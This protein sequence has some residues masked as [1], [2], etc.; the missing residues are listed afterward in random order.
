[1]TD[2][3]YCDFDRSWPYEQIDRIARREHKCDECFHVIHQHEPYERA[4]GLCEGKWFASKTCIR[5]LALREY[6]VAHVPCCCWTHGNM[7]EDVMGSVEEYAYATV[8]LA[9]GALRR[10]VL[11][12]R[13]SG[14][15]YECKLKEVKK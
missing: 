10:K 7:I 4:T 11:I 13:N 12:E 8:G 9:F 2:A 6:V 5:C 15:V 3:C 1:M 14:K